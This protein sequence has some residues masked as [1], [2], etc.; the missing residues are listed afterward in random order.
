MASGNHS[1]INAN[2]ASETPLVAVY[3]VKFAFKVVAFVCAVISLSWFFE[4][5][6]QVSQ[7]P[8][9]A[10]VGMLILGTVCTLAVLGLMGYWTY[11]EEKAKG[12]L[13]KRIGLYEQ[14]HTR[15]ELRSLSRKQGENEHHV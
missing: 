6:R 5:W 4:G 10:H 8:T 14:I 7:A 15:L 13:R 1:S 3:K 2:G 9:P 12:T 11:F